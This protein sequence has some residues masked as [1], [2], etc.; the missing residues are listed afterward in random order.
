MQ[1]RTFVPCWYVGQP[2]R[3]FKVK[4]FVDFHVDMPGVFGSEWVGLSVRVAPMLEFPL[5]R[6]RAYF[7]TKIKGF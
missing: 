2:M 7:T 6:N 1:A 4:L 3:S 5:P